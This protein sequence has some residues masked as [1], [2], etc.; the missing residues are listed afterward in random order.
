MLE[1]VRRSLA[2]AATISSLAVIMLTGCGGLKARQFSPPNPTTYVFNRS[3]T[4]VRLAMERAFKHRFYHGLHYKTHD[5][6]LTTDSVLGAEENRNDV[7][8]RGHS[9]T[10]GMSDVYVV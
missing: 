5:N 2:L 9:D 6:R 10:I 7:I 1:C 4:D 3:L 8:L